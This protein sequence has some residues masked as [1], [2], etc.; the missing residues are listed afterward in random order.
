MG[1]GPNP[2]T[3]KASSPWARLGSIRE[4]VTVPMPATVQLRV[5]I[6]PPRVTAASVD[7]L[8]V[9]GS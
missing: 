4:Q 9:V 6:A 3:A 7:T 5:T 2:G 8:S 1:D